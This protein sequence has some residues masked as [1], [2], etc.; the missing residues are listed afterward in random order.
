[1]VSLAAATATLAFGEKRDADSAEKERTQIEAEL[2]AVLGRAIRV[3][4]SVGVRPGAAVRSAVARET[5]AD[6]ADRKCGKQ[7]PASTR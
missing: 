6:L 1:M 7:K 2:S 4:F 3:T 5:D